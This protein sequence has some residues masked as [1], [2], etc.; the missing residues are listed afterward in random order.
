MSGSVKPRAWLLL[1]AAA[2][3]LGVPASGQERNPRPDPA[4]QLPAPAYD[5][6]QRTSRYLTMRDGVRLAIDI[7]RPTRN[8]Q[9]HDRALPVIW[10][11]QRYHRASIV[12]GR[13][14]TTFGGLA[15]LLGHGYVLAVVDAR[16]SGASFGSAPGFYGKAE[17]AD[18]YEVTEWLAAE[19]WSTGKV[20]MF[21]GSYLGH[22]QYFAAGQRPPHLKAIFPEMAVMDFYDLAYP[23][24]IFQEYALPTWRFLT[25]NLDQSRTFEWFG[26][27]MGPV[28]PVDG[29]SGE[30]LRAS[31][32]ADH[33]ANLDVGGLFQAVPYRN[34][35]EP[36]TGERLHLTR[37]PMAYLA[38]INRSGVA[39]YH[40]TG[41]LDGAPRH[42]IMM[43]A[44]LTVPERLLIGPW[45]HSERHGFDLAAERLRWYDY[46]LKGIDNG[47]M[48]EPPIRYGTLNA[49][50]DSTWRSARR[51]PLPEERRTRYY[52]HAGPSGSVASRN[53]GT[54]SEK[55]VG[56]SGSDTQTVDTTASVGK[57]NRWTNGYGG[58][59]GYPDLAVNDARGWTYTS[60]PLAAAV[61]VT[62]HPVVRLWVTADTSDVDVYVYLEEVNPAGRSS[63]VT[64]GMLRAS[65]GRLGRAPYRNFG[66]PYHPNR[67]EDA[68]LV[69]SAR[70]PVELVF[71]LM[72]T[73]IIFRKDHR[74]RLTITGADRDN[75]PPPKRPPT[76][77]LHRSSRY[78]SLV[79]L[80]VIP[81][82]R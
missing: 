9:L 28:A 17:L 54:L 7:I 71:D 45:F 20:G 15:S 70:E 73:S 76:I 16:G 2:A 18:T 31:A 11:H 48:R 66:L 13:L 46:W 39:I 57:A 50:P 47:V 26:T 51:W 67:A 58:P 62:G 12:D 74:I 37:S 14:R 38:A 10:A 35:V 75:F 82:R 44:N 19:P 30:A 27:R 81:G 79:E 68:P 24:G 21:G 80:P 59:A 33:E 65:R 60:A 61:E 8:G 3:L 41:W 36:T 5:G 40:L 4:G 49:H 34:S 64:D 56:P 69:L 32:I 77:A 29:D 55:R 63:F 23:G 72:P 42:M 43:Y 53:D 22:I 1:G 25:K 52:L 78:P 6:Y